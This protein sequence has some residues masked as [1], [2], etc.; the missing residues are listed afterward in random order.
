MRTGICDSSGDDPEPQVHDHNYIGH[1]YIGPEPQV[2][3][4]HNYIG[5]NYIGP[6]PQVHAWLWTWGME[7]CT[8]HRTSDMH[9]RHVHWQY[10]PEVGTGR[11]GQVRAGTERQVQ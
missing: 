5:H 9:N 6:E 11:C 3:R 1:N 8:Q 7:M 4:S 10:A 2:H